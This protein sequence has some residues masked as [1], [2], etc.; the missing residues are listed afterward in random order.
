MLGIILH[1]VLFHPVPPLLLVFN[2][3]SNNRIVVL[4]TMNNM[5]FG[6]P[7]PSNVSLDSHDGGKTV[8]GLD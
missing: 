7:V 4:L 5:P 2:L 6:Q 8:L 3:S 1:F